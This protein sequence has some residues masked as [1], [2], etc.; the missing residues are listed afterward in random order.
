MGKKLSQMTWVDVQKEM[1]IAGNPEKITILG[2]DTLALITSRINSK[3]KAELTNAELMLQRILAEIRLW[4]R[5]YDK[6][7]QSPG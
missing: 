3:N 2:I 6:N 1:S 7:H 5:I 4:K